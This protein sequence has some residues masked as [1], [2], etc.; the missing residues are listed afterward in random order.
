MSDIHLPYSIEG[1]ILPIRSVANLACS[2][3]KAEIATI[4]KYRS[5][6]TRAW[7]ARATCQA[8]D[9]ADAYDRAEDRRH[10]YCDECH[11]I[12]L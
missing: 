9:I 10:Y 5:L 7:F 8:A 3:V 12:A 1:K 11:L 2:R 6:S 4:A